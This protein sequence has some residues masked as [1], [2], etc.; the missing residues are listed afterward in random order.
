MPLLKRVRVLAA[1][2][3]STAGTAEALSGTEA[4][5]NIFNAMIQP[6][7]ENEER[8]GQGGLSQLSAVPGGRGG[9]ATFQTELQGDGAGGIPAWAS[10]FLPACGWIASSQVYSP[11][12]ATGSNFK[13]LTLG[14]YENGLY[15]Q[16]HGAQGT[17]TVTF[18]SRRR[19]L[20]DWTFTGIYSEPSDVSILTPTYT[21]NAP[22]SFYAETLTL[23]SWTPTLE[24]V[25]L[26]AG[27]E[28]ILREDATVSAGYKTALITGRRVRGTMN[29]EA[30]LVAT[31]NHVNKWLART[32]EALTIE[33]DNGTDRVTFAAPKCQRINVTEGERSGNQ[34][35]EIEFQCNRSASA[36]SDELT[37]TFASTD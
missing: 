22:M 1:K 27:N 26:D 25:T 36:G 30:V 32:E 37:I 14:L 18:P 2:I 8:E 13:T 23:G 15:K 29:P 21:T 5:F 33:I 7:I 4:T 10:T 35:D 3:E 19:V 31:A 6:N 11:A 24:Q 12:N 20:F 34:T 17:F 16:L 28:V 9:T